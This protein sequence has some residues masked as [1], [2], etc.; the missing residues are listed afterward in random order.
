MSSWL[1]RSAELQKVFAVVKKTAFINQIIDELNLKKYQ[2]LL[3]FLHSSCC[4]SFILI[5]RTI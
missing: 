2:N 4:S 5:C 1:C 3:G